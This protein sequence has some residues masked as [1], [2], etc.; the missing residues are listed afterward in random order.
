MAI[1]SPK[2]VNFEEIIMLDFVKEIKESAKSL[3]DLLQLFLE[4]DMV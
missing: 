3:F 1:K 2:I 4:K